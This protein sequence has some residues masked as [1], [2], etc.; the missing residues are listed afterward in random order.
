MKK[1]ILF[2]MLATV[3]FGCS[4]EETT[5]SVKCMYKNSAN[6]PYKADAASEVYVYESSY[7][8]QVDYEKMDW[9]NALAGI[10]IDKSGNELRNKY[11]YHATCDIN[12]E[13]TIN[14]ESGF[15]LVLIKSENKMHHFSL[16]LEDIPKEGKTITK[17]F[18]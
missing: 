7:S 3:A 4:Q 11:K 6:E 15:W 13:A 1:I 16:G 14:L 12:G 9:I 17:N 2:A 8:S 5:L 18:F 10:L